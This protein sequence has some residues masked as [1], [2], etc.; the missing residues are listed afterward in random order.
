MWYFSDNCGRRDRECYLPIS[1]EA[2]RNPIW[3]RATA[4]QKSSIYFNNIVKTRKCPFL[5]NVPVKRLH[6]TSSRFMPG[7]LQLITLD[8]Y[9]L[10]TFLSGCC[11][12]HLS[13]IVCFGLFR[14]FKNQHLNTKI[15]SYWNLLRFMKFLRI[16][17]LLLI[18][19]LIRYLQ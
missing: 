19:Y 15:Y 14:Y 10:A 11:V 1:L 17:M 3:S 12:L 9:D 4:L 5:H 16:F 6:R 7:E 8:R 13:F 2:L 18:M